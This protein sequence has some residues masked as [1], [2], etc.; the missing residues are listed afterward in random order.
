MYQIYHEQLP[1]R[2]IEWLNDRGITQDLQRQFWIGW[3]GTAITIP[4]F[5]ANNDFL[6]F[7]FR[8]DPE[9]NNFSP[10]YWY[11]KGHKVALFNSGALP[12]SDS[13]VIC[14]GE[15]D[16][17]LLHKYNIA[18]VTSTGGAGTIISILQNYD[19]KNKI[20][21]I[22]TDRDEAG[23]MAAIKLV[24]AL[25]NARL[26][27]LPPAVGQHGD[28]TDFFIKLNK[29]KENFLSLMA[30]ALFFTEFKQ[31][32]NLAEAIKNHE[33]FNKKKNA[34]GDEFWWLGKYGTPVFE[35]YR[36]S[37]VPK[38]HGNKTDDLTEIKKIPIEQFYPGVLRRVGKPKVGK[39]PLHD[40]S[41]ASF[42]L[43]PNNTW[44]CFGCA[45]GGDVLDFIMKKNNVDFKTALN[46][47]KNGH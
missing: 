44:Y 11:E 13:L 15:F 24:T 40:D 33:Q 45:L 8:K 25:P 12:N 17:M 42:C 34:L 26:I 28:I 23:Y 36:K 16:C 5:D 31:P 39:C 7:K 3:N 32:E 6:F 10:K 27:S 19:L 46:F 29:T 35:N 22:C 30:N 20:I 38:F 18:A 41:T 9:A 43:Y 14:E 37:F 4:I 21:Y 2:I 1:E 47:L